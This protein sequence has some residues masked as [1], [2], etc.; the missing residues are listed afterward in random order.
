MYPPYTITS[1]VLKHVAAI[2]ERLAVLSASSSDL[3]SLQLSPKLRRENR[4]RTI[5]ASLAIESNTLSLEQ[6]TAIIDGKIVIGPARDIQEVCGAVA[7]YEQLE[8]WMPHSLEDLLAAHALL[9]HDLVSHPGALRSK[10]VGVFKDG[11]VVHM[12]PP[13]S[14]VRE[15]L[16]N[17]LQWLHDTEEHP[18]IA[19][20]VFHYEFEFIHPFSDGNGRMGRLWQTL[21]LS[22]WKPLLAYLPVETIIRNR[23]TEYYAS[24][25]QAD[26]QGSATVF[27]EFM[28][29]ALCDIL[30]ESD[31][32]DQVSVQVTDQVRRLLAVLA[33]G[34]QSA[35][36]LLAE[37]GLRHTPSFRKNYLD[38]AIDAGLVERTQP[39]SPRSPTQRYRLTAKGRKSI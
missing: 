21:I 17:L 36:A 16:G 35:A 10:G 26:A 3:A 15:H 30:G 8:H 23:Q 1:A 4:I 25:G 28:L 37:L 20:S 33:Q 9:M 13:A 12:A 34:E 31:L 38:S 11:K 32:T 18:L 7:A 39:D 27:L 22:K 19:S 29:Q 5:H 2:S 14:L 6:V 24:L